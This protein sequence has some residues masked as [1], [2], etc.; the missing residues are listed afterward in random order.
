MF[1]LLR[2]QAELEAI[3]HTSVDLIPTAGL[4]PD[5]RSRV[6]ADLVPL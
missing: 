5:V 6:A 1:D 3:V 4:K 2:L